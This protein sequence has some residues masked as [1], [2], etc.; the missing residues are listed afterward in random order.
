LRE[1]FDGSAR[2]K[3][4]ASAT[5]ANCILVLIICHAIVGFL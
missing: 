3:L 4:R 5:T 2:A 1:L